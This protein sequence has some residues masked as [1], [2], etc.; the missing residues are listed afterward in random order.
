MTLNVNGIY[1]FIKYIYI[2]SV[3]ALLNLYRFLFVYVIYVFIAKV[4]IR[5]KISKFLKKTL[6]HVVH[7]L[8]PNRK[9]I[10]INL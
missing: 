7:I 2:L 6:E 1:A 3:K 8:A 10:R 4:N 9:Q 5:N